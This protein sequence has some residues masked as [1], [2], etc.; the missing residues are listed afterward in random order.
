MAASSRRTG[1]V[2]G[3]SAIL[4]WEVRTIGAAPPQTRAY[5]NR[6]D[7]SRR[8][9]AL[10]TSDIWPAASNTV[11][12]CLRRLVVPGR[13]QAMMSSNWSARLRFQHPVALGALARSTRLMVVASAAILACKAQVSLS[14]GLASAGQPAPRP[15]RTLASSRSPGVGRAGG[16]HLGARDRHPDPGQQRL[17]RRWPPTP[18]SAQPGAPGR[19]PAPRRRRRRRRG[20]PEHLGSNMSISGGP[21]RSRPCR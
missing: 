4:R 11:S 2:A 9:P 3:R 8:R 21:G 17:G 19:K 15:A 5:E 14:S 6:I 12:S 18:L 7:D 13:S 16:G 10:A 20:R 1:S